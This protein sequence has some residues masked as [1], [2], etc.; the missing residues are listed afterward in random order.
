ME[1]APALLG[2]FE[3]ARVELQS[4]AGD[5]PWEHSKFRWI[6]ELQSRR[7]GKA[8]EL[9]V[10]NWLRSEGFEVGRSTSS[11]SDRSVG[12]HQVEIKLSTLWDTGQFVFQQLRDQDYRYVILL[13]ITPNEARIWVLPKA[14]AMR[15]STPQ[16]TGASGAE[17]RWLS[18]DAANPPAWITPYGGNTDQAL[19]AVKK[20]L[21]GRAAQSR[22]TTA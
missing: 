22:T 17:T 7:R 15:H 20:Y 19:V 6:R 14:V 9:V 3:A 4:S 2:A 12:L 16:H 21:G 10:T 8:G 18:F 5:D 13:G 11:D 1:T